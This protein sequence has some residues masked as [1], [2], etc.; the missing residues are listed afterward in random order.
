[1]KIILK[2]DVINLGYK[3]DVVEVTLLKLRTAMPA[4]ISFHKEKLSW[5]HLQL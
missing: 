5:L 2:E 4:T 1:M 3:D